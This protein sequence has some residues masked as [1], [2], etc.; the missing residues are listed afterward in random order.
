MNPNHSLPMMSEYAPAE[1]APMETIQRQ[2][3]SLAQQPLISTLLNSVLDYVLIL[4]QQLNF[5]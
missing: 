3:E 1:R 2:A 5:Y 4:N